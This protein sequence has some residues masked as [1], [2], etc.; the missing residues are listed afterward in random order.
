MTL[1]A[2]AVWYNYFTAGKEGIVLKQVVY[3]DVLFIINFCMDYLALY[4]TSYLL[5]IKYK[6]WGAFISAMLGSLYSLICIMNSEDHIVFSV[7]C[8]FI[9]CFVAFW[10]NSKKYL[11]Y[12]VIV[13]FAVNFLLGGGMTAVFNLF[14]SLGNSREILI[15]GELNTV[16]KN[17]PL[18]IFTLGFSLITVV[19]IVFGRIMTRESKSR[20]AIITIT[21]NN[22][23][24][25]FL[26]RED[27]GNL[28]TEVVSGESVIFLTES[29]M[30]RLFNQS[31][32]DAIKNIDLPKV[33]ES[34]IKARILVYETVSG[35]ELCACIK[36]S[37]IQ[38]EDKELSAWIAVGKN[39]SFGGCEGIAPSAA[40]S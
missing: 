10:G 18:G 37:K 34:N 11:L 35:K 2:T 23:A 4:I 13:F 29:A 24:E 30:L 33:T 21:V 20:K 22:E 1:F 28:L 17:M 25:N 31:E 19:A 3:G 40:L 32:L 36:P 8:A 26:V 6:R 14:N 9:M 15:F 16:S 7:L 12:E 27:S 5:R 38:T 39:M